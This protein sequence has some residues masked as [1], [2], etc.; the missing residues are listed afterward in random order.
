MPLHRAAI[1]EA[2]RE[3]KARDLYPD[4]VSHTP[5]E[6]REF[7]YLERRETELKAAWR[8]LSN[9][10]SRNNG[11]ELPLLW[12]IH[13]ASIFGRRNP[14]FDIIIGNPPY[15]STQGSSGIDYTD[16][17]AEKIGFND[18][19]YVFFT[20][21]AFGLPRN[22]FPGIVREGGIVCLITSD[23]YFTLQ[24]K[25]RMRVLLQEKDLR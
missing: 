12:R 10:N 15:I 16:G 22:H 23:T 4:M 25:E 1:E 2:L 19:F 11:Q 6:N 13:F 20:S 5:D 3:R 7:N 17:L 24:T 14:G 18:D 8:T 21:R 9:G